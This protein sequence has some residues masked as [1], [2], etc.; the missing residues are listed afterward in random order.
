MDVRIPIID[1]YSNL[2][3]P[4][5]GA[6]DDDA[7]ARLQHD[8]TQRIQADGARGLVIDVSGVEFLDSFMTKNL[9][10]LALT[11]RLMGVSAVVS[12]LRP[13]V[14]ITL[15]EMGLEIPG[16]KTTLNLERALELLL[17]LQEEEARA[18]GEGEGDH[19]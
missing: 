12:G 9:R 13:A 10:D 14:A 17:S 7:M 1:L 16:V 5:Q 3:V 8:V 6:I 18:L 2:V 11:A 15:V 19:G 4:I